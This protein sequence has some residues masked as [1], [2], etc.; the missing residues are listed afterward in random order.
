MM[1][2]S[3][4]EGSEEYEGGQ[5]EITRLVAIIDSNDGRERANHMLIKWRATAQDRQGVGNV[6]AGSKHP[7]E[8]VFAGTQDDEEYY[9][10][11]RVPGKRLG[12]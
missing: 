1:R 5:G 9:R 12:S 6:G 11:R 3:G 10:R 4:D 8:A 7:A 2:R